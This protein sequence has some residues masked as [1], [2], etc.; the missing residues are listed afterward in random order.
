LRTCRCK[1][2]S[3]SC[4]KRFCLLL[5]MLLCVL[6]P[7][8]GCEP[9]RPEV[10]G[11]V[12]QATDYSKLSDTQTLHLQLY[13]L[14]SKGYYL[15]TEMR[16]V[17]VE[18]GMSWAE[19]AVRELLRG[20][21]KGDAIR[22][23]PP[24]TKIEKVVV[25]NRLANVY[26]GG[27]FDALSLEDEFAARA[28]I[29]NTLCA[30]QDIDY[31]GVYGGSGYPELAVPAAM[32]RSTDTLGERLSSLQAKHK[33]GGGVNE[34]LDLPLY[35]M[36]TRGM[37]LLPEV[38]RCRTASSNL[39]DVVVQELMKGP[40]DPA[41]QQPVLSE[42][43]KLLS[44]PVETVNA[45][46]T[47]TVTLDFSGVPYR[48]L[49]TVKGYEAL[50]YAAIVYSITSCMPGVDSVVFRI[51]GKPVTK[52]GKTDAGQAGRAARSLFGDYEG[53]SVTLY[54]PNEEMD[55]LLPVARALRAPEASPGTEC[56]RGLIIGPLE[57]EDDRAWPV[58]PSS[59]TESDVL[60]VRLHDD[61]AIVDVT[62][63]FAKACRDAAPSLEE[64]SVLVYSIV[65]TMTDL[66]GVKRVRFLVEGKT[67]DTLG[68]AI[69]TRGTLMRN[70]GVIE[71][72]PE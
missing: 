19:K 67:V 44:R 40:S 37:L 27:A 14:S 25:A 13:F 2:Y 45:D 69:S 33:D 7:G 15:T 24:G 72:R 71:K 54:F 8:A 53:T 42:T 5:A 56:M 59:V 26:L 60:S 30:F 43:V 39:V 47:R 21:K 11:P 4:G 35:F 22:C 16:T 41:R 57:P 64:E 38:R 10:S 6:V 18:Q 51:N 31:V 66:P 29:T 3:N 12:P 36:D 49:Y 58:I 23:L 68:G 62:S 1:T 28:A 52:L 17:R 34:W 48:D 32:S 65:N 63:R 46:G 9:K 50:P 55:A 61:L 20:P 70:A